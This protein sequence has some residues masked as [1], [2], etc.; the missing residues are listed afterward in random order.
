MSDLGPLPGLLVTGAARPRFAAQGGVHAG[1]RLQAT[2]TALR[3]RLDL[4]RQ[5]RPLWPL[6]SDLG[7]GPGA[8]VIGGRVETAGG[9]PL[10]RRVLVIDRIAG[11]VVRQGRSDSIT[12]RVAF[13]AAAGTA[14]Y[15][16][17]ALDDAPVYNAAR[18][19]DVQPA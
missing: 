5:S 11:L 8:T 19:D 13:P 10:A 1:E 12:G 2:G 4:G 14:R 7:R 6:A 17:V 9:D 15:L 16:V 3:C 18:I